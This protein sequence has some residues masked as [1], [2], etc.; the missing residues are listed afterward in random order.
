MNNTCNSTTIT[1]KIYHNL[2]I[3]QQRKDIIDQ[4]YVM[5]RLIERVKVANILIEEIARNACEPNTRIHHS[6]IQ[7]QS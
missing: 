5:T 1:F 4:L 6:Q 2:D 3:D 7:D